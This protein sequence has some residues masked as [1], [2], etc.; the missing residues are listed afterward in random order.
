VYFNIDPGYGPV[1]G[2]Y[3]EGNQAAKAIFD[4]WLE[5]FKDLGAR[6]N[7][8]AGIGATD[9]LSFIA[10]GVPGFNPVQEFANYDVRIHHTNMDTLERM[11]PGDIEEAAIVFAAFAYN[12]AMRSELI[13]RAAPASSP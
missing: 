13:P 1:Y 4:T 3:T 9:H 2:F 11:N 7:V 12:A 10:Q 8:I 6:K 5:P